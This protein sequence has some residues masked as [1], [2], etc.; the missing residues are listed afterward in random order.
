MT[1]NFTFSLC[2]FGVSHRSI[3]FIVWFSPWDEAT[4]NWQPLFLEYFNYLADFGTLNLTAFIL[5]LCFNYGQWVPLEIG[6]KLKPCLLYN[7]ILRTKHTSNHIP[8]VYLTSQLIQRH[9]CLQVTQTLFQE[10]VQV[11]DQIPQIPKLISTKQMNSSETM[12]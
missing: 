8:S 1:R 5:F 10:F 3:C 12:G 2:K 9:H 7:P 6:G 4:N 11:S